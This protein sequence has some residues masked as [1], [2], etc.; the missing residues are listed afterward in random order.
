[1]GESVRLE[2][3]GIPLQEDESRP[4]YINEAVFR[5]NCLPTRSYHIPDTSLLLN[6]TWDFHLASTPL[7]APEPTATKGLA[8]GGI[9]VPG[10]WQLQGHGKPWYTNVQY[11]IPVCPPYVPTENP[12]GSYRRKFNV[13]PAWGADSQL[14][15]RFEG[16]DSAYHVWVNGALVGY[17]QGSR[18]P[19]EFDISSFVNRHGENEL[20]V[21]VYQWSDATYIED[22]DQWWLS[23]IFRDVRLISFPASR[24]EDFFLRTDLDA[25]YENA[26]LSATVDVFTGSAG[27]IEL[28]LSELDKNGGAVIG[29]TEVPVNHE[30]KKA[31]LSLKVDKPSKWTAETPYLYQTEIVLKSA[32]SKISH[33]VQQR[34]G[35]R[36]V[37][38]ING[39]M[40]VNGKRIR[41]RGV[42]RHE[43]HPLLGR[44]VPL[45]FAKRDLLLMKTHNI[46][47]L[48]CAHQ[49]HDPRILDLCDELGLWVMGEA[50]LECHGFYDAVARPL[51]IPEEMDY[52]ERKKLAFPQAAQF[53]SNNPKWKDAYLDRIQAVI[54]RDKNHAS[55]IIW[56]LGNEAFYGDNHKAMF[57]Y[58][59]KVDPGRLVHYEGDEQAVTTHMYS[60]MYPSVEKLIQSCK[61]EG[62]K[63]GKFDKPIVLCEYGHAMGNGPGW[64]EDYEQAFREYPRLQGGFIWEWANHGLWKEEDGQGF[65]AY[66]GDFGDEPNDGTFVMDGL[67]SSTHDPTPGLTEYKKVIQ[68]VG[69]SLEGSNLIVENWHDFADLS[70]LGATFQVEALGETS[71]LLQAGSLEL[72]SIAAGE[73][74]S[75]PLPLDAKRYGSQNE[76]YLTV[77]LTLK[78]ATSW[79]PAGHQIAWFQHQLQG[80]STNAFATTNALT[81]QL[82]VSQEG[83]TV[84]VAG[85]GFNF[86]FDRARGAL[87]TWTANGHTLLEADPTTGVAISPSFWRPK[88]DN[89][90]PISLPYWKRFGVDALTSQ[91]RSFKVDSSDSKKTVIK[92]HTFISPPVLDWGWNSE[93]E[94]TVH[95]TGAL[96]INVVRL[97]P[98]GSFP[99]HVPRI[100]LNVYGNKGLEHVNWF[101]LGPGESYPDKKLSQRVGIW[102]VESVSDLHVHYDVPQENGNRMEARWLTL[103]DAKSPSIGLKAT[104]LGTGE[105]SHFNFVVSRH[106]D[107]TI[108]KAKHPHNLYEEDATLFR[109]DAKVAG[110][111]TAACGPGVRDDLLVKTEEVSF[112]FLI[113]PL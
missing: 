17:A 107:D 24:V 101:G 67:V 26:T 65:Y 6:G 74:T 93:I 8:W 98:T 1:M 42:N 60:Y 62:V 106:R 102:G 50:D 53:T 83:P 23:G 88:T 37:E 73:K 38:L 66:G 2:P 112:D 109:L 22:Q 59:T 44:S 14:R 12:T 21:R 4:D 27:T 64:L 61:E 5:R 91:L 86:T 90:V 57:E 94:Y 9:Q 28:T 48:R 56:S 70:H 72:P 108:Q 54:N 84:S 103:R 32:D 104:R 45:E 18:N 43:H 46:N 41:L 51:D 113:E 68:P 29:K 76:V 78:Q 71:T 7:E 89:D 13:P 52:G 55:I 85:T 47:A 99:E 82:S 81:S 20:F 97:A 33:K 75:I 25:A 15:L 96:G 63:D 49:P 69:F 92:A 111:G 39:L 110:V 87:K 11:P 77:T 19:S 31:E 58:A 16:V 34:I 36:K 79:A 105:Q 30:T 80:P 40:T 35:F 100:G 95:V 3:K 10:H